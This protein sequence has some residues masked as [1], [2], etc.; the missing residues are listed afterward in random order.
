MKSI[1]YFL[2]FITCLTVMNTY[3][4]PQKPQLNITPQYD[5]GVVSTPINDVAL[6]L[7]MITKQ[8]PDIGV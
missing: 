3:A 7:A 4:Q 8:S 2:W 5:P 6:Y 1:H